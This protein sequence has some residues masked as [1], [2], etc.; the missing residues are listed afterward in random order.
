VLVLIRTTSKYFSLLKHNPSPAIQK[1]PRNSISIQN[2]Q[3]E[4]DMRSTRCYTDY[5]P[6]E[7][8]GAVDGHTTKS[9]WTLDWDTIN[10]RLGHGWDTI[11]TRLRHGKHM[12]LCSHWS[13]VLCDGDNSRLI[14]Y[15]G[16]RTL[17]RT[18][19]ENCRSMDA[20]TNTR[21]PGFQPRECRS[22]PAWRQTGTLR[23]TTNQL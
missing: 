3:H 7:S 12:A 21:N 17:R 2:G 11:N 9:R 5:I 18:T 20:S 14:F 15:V 4:S 6:R 8:R 23:R 13:I 22:E 19:H 16:V 1:L 10:T